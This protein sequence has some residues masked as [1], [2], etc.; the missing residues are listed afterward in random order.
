M[1]ASQPPSTEWM[2]FSPAQHTR[3]GPPPVTAR[4]GVGAGA[5]GRFLGESGARL[6]KRARPCLCRA[7]SAH[8]VC[9]ACRQAGWQARSIA[10]W[11]AVR[12]A[13]CQ[14]GRQGRAGRGSLVP[15]MW[16]RMVGQ[17]DSCEKETWGSSG[18]GQGRHAGRTGRKWASVVAVGGCEVHTRHWAGVRLGRTCRPAA[19]WRVLG[20]GGGAGLPQRTQQAARAG[21]PAGGGVAGPAPPAWPTRPVWTSGRQPAAPP[22]MPPWGPPHQPPHRLL[23]EQQADRKA[24][25]S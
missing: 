9:A 19:D 24:C 20:G 17:G 13:G 10:C 15:W 5:G 25:L 12:P 1:G 11:Q 8:V 16:G 6:G 14:V 4:A 7:A 21:R 2:G 23:D 22:G 3:S 18:F